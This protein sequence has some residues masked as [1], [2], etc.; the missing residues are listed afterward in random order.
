MTMHRIKL[1]GSFAEGCYAPQELPAFGPALLWSTKMKATSGM[2]RRGR[3][4]R[5]SWILPAEMAAWIRRSAKNMGKSQSE[6]ARRLLSPAYDSSFS[7]RR[8]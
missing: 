2:E 4:A 7:F 8:G 3:V 6:L 1:A 5:V